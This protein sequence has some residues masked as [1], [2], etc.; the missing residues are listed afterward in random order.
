ML[1]GFNQSI[2]GETRYK[3]RLYIHS[4]KLMAQTTTNYIIPKNQRLITRLI[5]LGIVRKR[6]QILSIID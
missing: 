2:L 4:S 1:Q 5:I 3:E 6:E